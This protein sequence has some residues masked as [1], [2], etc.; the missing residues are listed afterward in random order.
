MWFLIK[1][2]CAHWLQQQWQTVASGKRM[3][4][5]SGTFTQ[6][7]RSYFLSFRQVKTFFLEL[8]MAEMWTSGDPHLKPLLK[9]VQNDPWN[10]D[11]FLCEVTLFSPQCPHSES[12][13]LSLELCSRAPFDV[14]RLVIV[15]I[16]GTI[17]ATDLRASELDRL[18]VMCQP[19]EEQQQRRVSTRTQP[20]LCLS[21][22]KP[23]T[24]TESLHDEVRSLLLRRGRRLCV[25]RTS[26]QKRRE[27]SC[28]TTPITLKQT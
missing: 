20:L 2:Q 14:I 13:F 18:V 27:H 22:R 3:C 28:L 8:K 1:L 5:T 11:Q 7:F 15:V 25:C 16:I 10:F 17:A 6:T 12:R 9:N 21:V 19:V 4:L 23:K 24:A 26:L